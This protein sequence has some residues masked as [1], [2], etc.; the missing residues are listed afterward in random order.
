[1][2][3]QAAPVFSLRI[4]A[5][6]SVMCARAS[7]SCAENAASPTARDVAVGD[8]AVVEDLVLEQGGRGVEVEHFAVEQDLP[9]RRDRRRRDEPRRRGRASPPL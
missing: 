6:S 8:A 1:M 7:R 3:E 2:E 9:G 4:K 5:M